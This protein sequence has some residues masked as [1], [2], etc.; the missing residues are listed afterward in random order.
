MRLYNFN[1][2]FLGTR[3]SNHYNFANDL[4]IDRCGTVSTMPHY[5]LLLTERLGLVKTTIE[6]G[7]E[8][9]R[10]EVTDE[11]AEFLESDRKR[12]QAQDRSDR[13]HL[14]K[15]TFEKDR[16]ESQRMPAF[17]DETLFKVIH[18]MDLDKLRFCLRILSEPER[19]LIE[20][21]YFENYNMETIGEY[22]GIS[23]MA[24]SKRHKIII[25]KLRKL[26]ET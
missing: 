13:R 14:S 15:G 1:L 17:R 22:F 18:T 12:Q 9:I 20:K 25:K 21:Y 7:D 10:V 24:V 19:T 11:V 2:K 16:V 5:F 8:I 3:Q 4:E 26:M 6:Y 23:K